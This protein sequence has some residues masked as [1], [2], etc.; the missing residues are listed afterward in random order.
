MTVTYSCARRLQPGRH[1]WMVGVLL[2]VVSAVLPLQGCAVYDYLYSGGSV[3]R[4]S[5]R[6]DQDLLRSAESQL[7]R[8]QYE[9]ARKDLQRLMNQYPDSD[10]VSAA[11]LASAKALYMQ[12][13]YDESRAEYQRFLDLHP[14]HDRADEAHYYLGMTYFRQSDTPDRDQSFTRKALDEFDLLMTQMPDSQYVPDA[15]ERTIVCRQK[16]AEK[17]VYVGTF[18]YT[19][20]NY[21]AAVGRFNAMLAQYGGAGFDDQALYYLGESLWQLEQKTEARAAFHRLLQD[22]SQSEWAPPAARRLGVTLV[23]TGSPKP[24]GPGMFES[25]WQD[26]QQTWEEVVDTVKGYSIFRR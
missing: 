20:G 1:A 19:R 13:K 16:L 18:Y 9:D 26:M 4:E 10:L 7:Q 23:R 2:L 17:E 11:R 6:S 8:N 15:R 21:A 5:Q 12:R 3:R 22:H 25:M 24:P 14:Q